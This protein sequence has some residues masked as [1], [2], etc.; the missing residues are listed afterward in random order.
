MYYILCRAR[1]QKVHPIFTSSE[2]WRVKKC[3]PNVSP[4]FL[5]CVV[6]TAPL[7]ESV[8]V[9]VGCVSEGSSRFLSQV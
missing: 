8:P 4:L 5:V 7:L 6:T 2:R 3:V 9:F 1:V